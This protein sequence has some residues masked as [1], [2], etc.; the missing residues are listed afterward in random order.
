V[1]AD[2]AALLLR[3]R[4]QLAADWVRS[5]GRLAPALARRPADELLAAGR[6]ILSEQ[7]HA[8]QRGEAREVRALA[9]HATLVGLLRDGDLGELLRA[10]LALRDQT[11]DL[12]QEQVSEFPNLWRAA[13]ILVGAMD[14]LLVDLTV[15]H[16]RGQL[17]GSAVGPATSEDLA[18]VVGAEVRRALRFRRPVAV[19]LVATDA[20]EQTARVYGG[21]VEGSSLAALARILE[22]STREVDHKIPTEDGGYLIVLPETDLVPAHSIAERIRLAAEAGEGADPA[23]AHLTSTVSVGVATFPQHADSAPALL[24]AAQ[25]ALGQAQRLGGNTVVVSAEIS[26]AEQPT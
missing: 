10:L 17:P 5:L 23:L 6:L 25:D 11:L 12:L 2:P 7:I 20:H 3:Y 18:Q 24:A 13:R 9:G 16:R 14:L 8:L 15:R 19:L 22:Q 21:A 4:D 26:A 1:K